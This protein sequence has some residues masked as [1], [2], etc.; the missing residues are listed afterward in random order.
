MSNRKI[1]SANTSKT[2]GECIRCDDTTAYPDPAV[3]LPPPKI[4][5][6]RIIYETQLRPFEALNLLM[7]INFDR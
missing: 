4:L 5:F 2:R 6:F 3:N 1:S 7:Y